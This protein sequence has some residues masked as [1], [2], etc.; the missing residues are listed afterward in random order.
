MARKRLDEQNVIDLKTKRSSNY[1]VW[2]IGTDAER[3]L[4][5]LVQPSGTRTYR[6]TYRAEGSQK[7]HSMRLGRV[8]DMTLA[9]KLATR[10]TRL[11]RLGAKARTPRLMI[12]SRRVAS[13]SVSRCGP[14][15]SS[16]AVRSV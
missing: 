16:K 10:H 4:H 1:R 6:V 12:R 14:S 7:E 9:E 11:A 15:G 13:L 8:G 5:V 2:D 3:G